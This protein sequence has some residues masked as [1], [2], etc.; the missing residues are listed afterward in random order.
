MSVIE[1][2]SL[3][4]LFILFLIM[5]FVVQNHLILMQLWQQ[6]AER[7]IATMYVQDR[8]SPTPGTRLQP[9]VGEMAPIGMHVMPHQREFWRQK[10]TTSGQPSVYGVWLWGQVHFFIKEWQIAHFLVKKDE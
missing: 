5:F 3:A 9:K 1:I 6:R 2:V 8:A 10:K 7:D 4:C